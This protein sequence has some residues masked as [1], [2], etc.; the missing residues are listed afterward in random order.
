MVIH[1]LI[2]AEIIGMDCLFIY[3]IQVFLMGAFCSSAKVVSP[4]LFSK[5]LS[6][7]RYTLFD[8]ELTT[9]DA[10]CRAK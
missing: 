9:V 2:S 4:R 8:E 5:R 10:I 3:L 6:A 1:A 7:L